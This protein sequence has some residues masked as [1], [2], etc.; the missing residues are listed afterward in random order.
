MAWTDRINPQLHLLWSGTWQQGTVE[1]PRLLTDH[2]LVVV[3]RGRCRL[4]IGDQPLELTA[5]TFSI[6]PPATRHQ[7]LALS[8]TCLRHCLHFDWEWSERPAEGPFFVYDGR[9]PATAVRRAPTWL[10]SGLLTGAAGP[11]SIMLAQRLGLR[12]R[13][14]DRAGARATALD[15]LL[16]LLAPPVRPTAANRQEELA[17]LVKNRLDAGGFE[18]RSVRQELALLGHSYEHLCRSFV[19]TFGLPPLR[20][21]TLA[22]ME[23]AKQLLLQPEAHIATVAQT[24][25]YGDAAHFAKVFRH[26]TGLGP[27]QWKRRAAIT[28]A[29]P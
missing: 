23:R 11:E 1:P 21:L 20:Y 10:P 17:W 15:L 12:W 9:L 22:R 6:V 19:R 2:E 3:E 5:G 27:L 28:E 24:L 13:S 7:S 4:V 29:G 25:G 8:R 26:I 16:G 18:T 14:G